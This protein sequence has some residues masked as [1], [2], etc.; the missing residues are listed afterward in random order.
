[1][2]DLTREEFDFLIN[3]KPQLTRETIILMTVDFMKAA[4]HAQLTHLQVQVDALRK[5]AEWQSIDTVPKNGTEILVAFKR[6]G[7]K[8]VAWTTRN[9]DPTDVNAH[10][11]IDDNKYD[12]YPLRGYNEEDY[13]GWM[14][15]PQLPVI[16][17]AHQ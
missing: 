10:W 5:E 14:P 16:K 3:A 7:V 2:I 4:I 1:M 17:G 11:H 9:C 8:C 6:I 15:L 12:P 13:L